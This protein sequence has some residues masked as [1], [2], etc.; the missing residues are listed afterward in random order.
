MCESV[1]PHKTTGRLGDSVVKKHQS[2]MH[3]LKMYKLRT[4]QYF[5]D[6]IKLKWNVFTLLIN[7]PGLNWNYKCCLYIYIYATDDLFNN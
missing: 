1:A 7:I 3:S 4:L 6:N 2:K 5:K